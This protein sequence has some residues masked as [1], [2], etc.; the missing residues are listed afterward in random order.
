MNRADA[1]LVTQH[2]GTV[3]QASSS[4]ML[5]LVASH[6]QI[7]QWVQVWR[8]DQLCTTHFQM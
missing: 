1:T 4:L 8:A 3:G 6:L 2:T 5:I 7:V